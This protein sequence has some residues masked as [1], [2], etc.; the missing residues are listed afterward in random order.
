MDSDKLRFDFSWNGSISVNQ[1]EE[2]EKIVTSQIQSK[3]PV[4][5]ELVPLSAATEITALRKVFGEK[6]PDPVRVISVGQPVTALMNDPKNPTWR[7][8][9]IEFCGGTHLSNTGD[10]EE[11]CIIEENGIA[12]GNDLLT[13]SLTHSLTG[14]L[15]YSL[16]LL[17]HL[18][19]HLT[20]SLIL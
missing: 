5:A 20:Y 6:Y 4:Y 15:T 10:A 13:H 3:L 18:L 2:V 1:L 8:G 9:S 17:T 12:K 14:L 11:F 7:N 19:T 16:T